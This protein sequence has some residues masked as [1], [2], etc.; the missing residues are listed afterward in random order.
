[1]EKQRAERN[2]TLTLSEEEKQIFEKQIFHLSQKSSLEQ[3]ENQI[4]QGDLFETIDLLPENS[5]DLMIIDP[6]Y[7]LSK[8]FNGLNFNGRSNQE[9]IEYLESWFPKVIRLLKKDASLYIC[10]DWKCIAALYEVT[11]KYLKVRNRI[12]WQREK[13]RGASSNWKNCTE[14]IW[15]ATVSDEY[16]FDVNAVKQKKRVIAPY[17]QD[18]KPKDWQENDDGKYRLTCPSNFWDDISIPFWS[19]PENT[20]HPTQKPEKLIAKLILASSAPNAVVFDPFLG[21][22]TTAV[23]AAKL[24]RRFFGI[25]LNTEYCMWALKRLERAKDDK[26]IQG[27]E[28]GIFYERNMKN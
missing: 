1:M 13:G 11:S 17:K 5:V 15:F 8:N 20:D 12:T 26:S 14:D 16:Y 28:D 4:I 7:N 19:M 24:G 2:R 18:G 23:T 3:V 25:E 22:G 6:P 9:Y 21:S 27:Y 10:G